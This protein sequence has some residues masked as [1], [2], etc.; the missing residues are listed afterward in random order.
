M[1][2]AIREQTQDGEELVRLMLGVLRGKIA[3]VKLRDRIA[4]A[5][6]LADRGFGRPVQA[7]E[8][9]APD[10]EELI[11]L[12]VVRTIMADFDRANMRE[13]TG[14]LVGRQLR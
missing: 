13:A 10:G 1:V 5:T 6:W 7:L 4:A 3:G 11:P 12:E 2:R 8:H 14:E 9:S